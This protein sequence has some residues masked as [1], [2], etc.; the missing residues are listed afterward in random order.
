M[1][2]RSWMAALA[3][4]AGTSIV[5]GR[6][7]PALAPSAA[8]DQDQG[9]APGDKKAA[10]STRSEADESKKDKGQDPGQNAKTAET[11]SQSALTKPPTGSSRSVS[12]NLVIAGLGREGCDVEVKPANASCRFRAVDNQGKEGRSHVSSDGRA[13]MEL[14]DVELR[15]ADRTC[16]VA[17]TIHEKGRPAKTTYRGFRLA[18]QAD[19]TK[20]SMPAA[21]SSIMFYVR[22]PSTVVRSDDAQSRK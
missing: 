14:R 8:A 22:S 18:P 11:R 7:M 5:V 1:R 9:Q 13:K 4:I 20:D 12:V 2:A 17:I 16:T 10:T 6:A 3:L 21:R 19:S 15:G